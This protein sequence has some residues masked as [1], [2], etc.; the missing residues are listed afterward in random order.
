MVKKS[1]E[2]TKNI[3]L[4]FAG[5]IAASCANQLPPG[6]GEVDRVPPE[7]IELFPE[8]GTINFNEDHFELG[9]SEYVDKRSVKDAIFISPAIEGEL[10][11][12]WSGKYVEITFPSSLKKN[13]TYV[14]TLGT[15][16]VDYNNKNRMAQAFSFT[17]STGDKIDRRMISGR[18]YDEKPDGVMMFAYKLD[19]AAV[20]PSVLKPDYVSQ[21]GND[22]SF[23][24]LGLSAGTYRVF[25]VKD[26][27]RDLLYNVEQDKIGVPPFDVVLSEED[28]LYQGLNFF[29]TKNDT[30]PPRLLSAAMT[31]RN[32]II[33]NVS[34]EFD[35][36]IVRTT[37][38]IVIDS[39]KNNI[40]Y[41]R[42]SYRQTKK[43]SE[44]VLVI[45]DSLS[46]MS[47]CY[48]LAR[49][50]KDI[51][52]NIFEN[53]IISLSVSEKPDTSKPG[54][55]QTIPVNTSFGVDYTG[56]D[57]YFYFTDAFD[58][59]LIKQAI[60]FTDTF[61][62]AV[63]YELFFPDD[64]VLGIKTKKDLE[65]QKDYFIK[66]DLS[67][68]VDVAGNKYDSIYTF[69]FKT[70]S[71]LEFT[72]LSGVVKNKNPDEILVVLLQNINEKSL[73]YKKLVTQENSF[74]FDRIEAGKYVIWTHTLAEDENYRFGKVHPYKP[75]DWFKFHPDTLLLK[76]RWSLLDFVLDAGK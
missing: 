12:N 51:S 29:L 8:D 67:R 42:Y 2:L 59:N 7:I 68:V 65:V 15:D 49:Q 58:S 38:Y 64:A 71:G 70:I 17:F 46:D 54:I 40:I 52:G 41:P 75:A 63:Q 3:F 18:V 37:N 44:I 21:C 22:G 19:T 23:R 73:L 31:D 76:P 36:V 47:D 43:K 74:T 50:L 45:A 9:F 30:T 53:D 6:G 24:L 5:F 33:V 25:A 55:S 39:T 1:A 4:L 32:H 61:N 11:L 10:E 13:T 27:F 28:T 35:S 72:G 20:D 48:V 14:I 62:R 57:F 66:I 56:T 26:E 60:V 16:V 34:E 69:K